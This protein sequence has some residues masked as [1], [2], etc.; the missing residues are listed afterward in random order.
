MHDVAK[1]I[2]SVPVQSNARPRRRGRSVGIAI[3][4]LIV[5]LVFAFGIKALQIGKMMST[6]M[7]MPPTTVSS[8]TVKEEDWAPTLSAV[9]SISA[10]QGAIIAAELGGVVSDIKFENGGV[11]KKG[12]VIM[13]LDA[14]QE[15]AL[16]R[17]AEA[18]AELARQDLE[19]TRGLRS[20][21]RRVGKECR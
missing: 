2:S 10:V 17:S 11:A 3:G 15:E 19:R 14:S 20:E 4:L 18:E 12:D 9:G 16:L 13:K 5:I 7:V 8:A 6:P 1:G 21:E